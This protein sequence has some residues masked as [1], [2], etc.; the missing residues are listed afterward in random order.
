MFR[1]QNADLALLVVGVAAGLT[2]TRS[3]VSF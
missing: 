2:D 3:H 1:L